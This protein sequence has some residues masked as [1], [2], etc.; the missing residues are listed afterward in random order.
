MIEV[1]ATSVVYAGVANM[2]GERQLC[3]RDRKERAENT[4]RNFLNKLKRVRE[5][6]VARWRQ[7][8]L[9]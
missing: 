3:E 9:Y 8:R 4:A 7:S 1:N 6:M 5:K 2:D